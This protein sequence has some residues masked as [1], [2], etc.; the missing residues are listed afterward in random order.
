VSD[1]I[2]VFGGTFSPIHYGH[3]NSIV[4]VVKK[5][6]LD[7]VK[8]IPAYQSP[9]K[10]FIESPSPEDRLKL[11]E[12]GLSDYKD[13][14]QVDR[15]ELDRKGVSYSV[16]TLRSLIEKEPDTEF[17]LIIGLDQFKNFDRW[18]E[19][20]EILNLSHLVVT[21]RPGY[22]FPFEI[23]DFPD[24]LKDYIVDFDGY[25]ALLKNEKKINFLRLKDYDM[26]SSD[27]R[28]KVRLNQSIN[29]FVPIEVETYILD[30][31]LYSFNEAVDHDS[32]GLLNEVKSQIEA[33]GGR[34]PLAFDMRNENQITDFN[35]VASSQS[36][37]AN[38]MLAENMI[39]KIKSS[40]GVRP[41]G[42][43]G[44][45]EANWI[46]IDYGS[47]IVHL[48]YESLRHE[49]NLEALWSDYPKL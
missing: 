8:V 32:E 6:D 45:E 47:V 26:S 15:C 27:I 20:Y 17:Y 42:V 49:Y 38:Q 12:L 31:K 43:D 48:F 34:Q 28:K 40:L 44:K 23:A 37:R 18:K 24:G 16:D 11:V 1:K 41:L 2:G 22:N 7:S 46:V 25:E 29:K 36:K 3:I 21:S 10:D 4:N 14:V 39:E 30:N 5:M 9:G 35:V 19:F 13:L 33:L